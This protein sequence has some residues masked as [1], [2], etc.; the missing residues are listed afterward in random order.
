MMTQ[1]LRIDDLRHAM[2]MAIAILIA[3]ITSFY[4]GKY[5]V[6]AVLPS[7]FVA[8][9]MMRGVSIQHCLKFLVGLFLLLLLL[10]QL[11]APSHPVLVSI[12]LG[13]LIGT[14]SAQFI[15]PVNAGDAFCKGILPVLQSLA[16]YA[17][18]VAKRLNQHDGPFT[19][20]DDHYPEWVYEPGFN[21]GLRSG[22]RFFL[23]Q[24]ERIIELFTAIDYLLSRQSIHLLLS[25][26][27][28]L[29]GRLKNAFSTNT[30]LLTL[31][32]RYFESRIMPPVTADMTNDMRLLTEHINERYVASIDYL[33]I[34]PDNIAII[35]FLRDMNDVRITL[36]QL[37]PA[38]PE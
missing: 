23:L 19:V 18:A 30:E 36:L 33:D 25:N 9:Q 20:N 32:I 35:E 26:D 31:L 5:S 8:F 34:F 38:L 10:D 6:Y 16:N 37:I 2:S 24:I 15:L 21:P 22:F 3:A 11:L 29:S 27:A 28:E 12:M 14:M 1:L 17:N 4:L 7:A 13:A